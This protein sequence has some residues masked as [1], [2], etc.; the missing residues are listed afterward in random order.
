MISVVVASPF[1]DSLLIQDVE[2][3]GLKFF[4]SEEHV[5]ALDLGMRLM[6]VSS[7]LWENG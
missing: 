6:T 7:T 4:G 3:M 1:V 5:C 2:M